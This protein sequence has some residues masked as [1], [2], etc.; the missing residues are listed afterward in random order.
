MNEEDERI[1]AWHEIAKHP[2]FEDAY[3]DDSPLLD[4][5]KLR[6]D[7]LMTQPTLVATQAEEPVEWRIH[8]AF[9]NGYAEG[10]RRGI[11]GGLDR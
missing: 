1:E 6:L 4:A 3:N 11:E 9:R 7:R 10:L 8:R 2:F 5:M